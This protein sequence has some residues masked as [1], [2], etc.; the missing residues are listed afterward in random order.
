MRPNR[1]TKE[2]NMDLR[3]EMQRLIAGAKANGN[4]RQVQML[5]DRLDQL[6]NPQSAQALFMS[7]PVSNKRDK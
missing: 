1:G 4:D 3:K 2:K 7:A 6:E 5:Q